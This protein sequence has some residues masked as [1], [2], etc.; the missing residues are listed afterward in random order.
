MRGALAR[1]YVSLN[2]PPYNYY[3]LS[4]PCDDTGFVSDRKIY[5][6]FRW[7]IQILPRLS[8]WGGFEMGTGLEITSVLPEEA[9][10]YLRGQNI[11]QLLV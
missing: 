8:K 1:L 6:N 5:K 10:V 7:H 4:A 3:I 11:D 9:A 2:D